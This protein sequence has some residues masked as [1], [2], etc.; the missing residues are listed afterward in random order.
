MKLICTRCNRSKYALRAVN[1]RCD[2]GGTFAAIHENTEEDLDR[3]YDF[4]P[5]GDPK[6][7]EFREA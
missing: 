7:L 4:N 2:C 6:E 3:R 5:N 1:Q